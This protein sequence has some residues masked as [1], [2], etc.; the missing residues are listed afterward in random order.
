MSEISLQIPAIGEGL[1]EA[2]VVAILKQPGEHVKRDEIIYQMET[3]KAVMDVES[4]F[5]GTVVRWIGAVDQ[6]MP[7]GADVMVMEVNSGA[8][9]VAPTA[10]NAPAPASSAPAPAGDGVVSLRI[11]AIG[12][13]LQEARLVAKL[14]EAGDAISRD[15]AIYQMETDKAVMDVECP[16][17]GVMVEWLAE[18]D[19][20]LAIGA[21]VARIRTSDAVAD[22]APVQLEVVSSAAPA[23]AAAKSAPMSNAG[24]RRDLPPRTRAYAKDRGLT[25]E[26]VAAI[27]ATGKN[28]LPSDVDAFLAGGT[29]TP[30][31]APISGPTTGV[32]SSGKRFTDVPFAGRQRILSSRLQRG[33]QLVV[34]GMMSVVADWSGIEA[35]REEYKAAGGDFQPS[36]FT[37]FAYAV[38]KACADHPIMRSTLRGDEAIRTYENIQLGIAVARPGDELVVAVV[39]DADTLHWTD[40]AKLA[41]ERILEARDGQDQADESVTL[42]ITNMQGYGIRDAMAVVVPPGVATIFLG[43]AYN[44]LANDTNELKFMRCANIGI[45]IDHRLINGVG[46]AEFLNTIKSNVENIRN[47]IS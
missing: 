3:D 29:V 40:F 33:N 13:G 31:Q 44:G 20:V 47:L 34:P 7:I 37:I 39:P 35:A 32:S 38:A 24:R 16:H 1:Q 21:E 4:P 19:E 9:T 2:R 43:E 17:A 10:E 12:E 42:S 30:A 36:T 5:E 28:L 6:V 15:E 11:P 26:Q 23:P 22:A 14:K 8:P 27:P 45:T 46:G 18:V 41:R 25:D